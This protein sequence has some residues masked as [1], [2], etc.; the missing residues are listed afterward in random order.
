MKNPKSEIRNQ[1]LIKPPRLKPGNTIGIIAPSGPVKKE[2]LD[3]NIEYLKERG[4]RIK[5]GIHL[6]NSY[7]YFAGKDRDRAEDFN[8]MFADPEVNAIFCA[9]GGNGSTR[10]I[11]YIDFK[12]IRRNPKIFLGYSDIT[13]F[14]NA[15]HQLT[16]LVTFH[17][18]MVETGLGKESNA[19][20]REMVF[21]I[22]SNPE[23]VGIIPYPPDFAG[24][25][26]AWKVLIEGEAVGHSLAGCISVI[27][28]LLGTPYEFNLT[29][30][31]LFCEDVDEEPHRIDRMLAHFKLTGKL[32]YVKAILLGKLIRCEPKEPDKP[33][34][35]YA[36]IFQ[37]LFGDLG[38]PVIYDL[39][40]GHG[41]SNFPIP[42][43]IEM[44]IDTGKKELS[45][46][47]GAVL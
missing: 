4:Y 16:G 27:Q 38:I 32:K 44:K 24:G 15:I 6:Y 12:N 5:L 43:G 18:P 47:E 26:T 1:N 42:V 46:L 11:P 13:A 2:K 39:G 29:N 21:R 19:F 40:F 14:L 34:L 9:H 3:L 30:K 31:L 37:D 33:T 28:T 23:P 10:I 36:E 45:Y 17:S 8:R 25:P 20:C 7:G 35:S 41:D 22:L